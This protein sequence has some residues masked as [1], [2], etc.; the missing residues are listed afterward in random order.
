[1]DGIA[2]LAAVKKSE[3]ELAL[4][5]SADAKSLPEQARAADAL[6]IDSDG[7]A[8]FNGK[9][10]S[11][12]DE[13]GA[14]DLRVGAAWRVPG[15][16]SQKGAV[17]VG[18]VSNNIW[19]NG[20]VGIGKDKNEPSQSLDVAGT[21]AADNLAASGTVTAGTVKAVS[22][23]TNSGISLAAVQNAVNMAEGEEN[24]AAL[25]RRQ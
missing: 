16:Y 13:E 14:G 22:L 23:E 17:A 25:H 5:V 3:V 6:T 21:I 24:G 12:T 18:S 2:L 1:M 11:L 19:L 4:T 10:N 15:I 9:R 8:H 7:V 20:K